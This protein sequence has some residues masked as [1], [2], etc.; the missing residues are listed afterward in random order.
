MLRTFVCSRFTVIT[1]REICKTQ[2]FTTTLWD[3]RLAN[4]NYSFLYHNTKLK[5][6]TSSS[7]KFSRNKLSI[8]EKCFSIRNLLSAWVKIKSN[9]GTITRCS[10]YANL[11]DIKKEW[12]IKSSIALLKANFRHPTRRRIQISKSATTDTRLFTLNNPRVK[13][14]ERAI[15]NILEPI[16][17]GCW[18]WVSISEKE[19]F[20]LKR[21]S[22]TE[23]KR[24]SKSF[25]K[26]NWYHFPIFSCKSFGFRPNRSVHGAL[27]EIKH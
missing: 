4:L 9:L 27:H 21:E 12:F 6:L 16:F 5:F 24:N 13:I 19:Y 10:I 11:N 2:K 1:T 18:G 7:F 25:F 15:L 8:T 17:E 22:K 3:I 26:K 23:I 14:I 20:I